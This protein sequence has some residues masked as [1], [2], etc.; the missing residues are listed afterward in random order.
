MVAAGAIVEL[1]RSWPVAAH[2]HLAS[3]PSALIAVAIVIAV[4]LYAVAAAVR[5]ASRAGAAGR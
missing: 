3:S 2:G 1:Q 5:D 4:G